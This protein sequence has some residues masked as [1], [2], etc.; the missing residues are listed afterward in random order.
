MAMDQMLAITHGQSYLA[1]SLRCK[2]AV[3]RPVAPL[4]TPI[5]Y[6]ARGFCHMLSL[7][8]LPLWQVLLQCVIT[9]VIPS[10]YSP[11]FSFTCNLSAIVSTTCTLQPA[12][13]QYTHVVPLHVLTVGCTASGRRQPDPLGDRGRL[14]QRDG[15]AHLAGLHLPRRRPVRAAI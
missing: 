1:Q 15:A 12:H 2:R 13:P 11:H 5:A 10:N 14:V 4:I 3:C 7:G 6:T 8:T 9:A